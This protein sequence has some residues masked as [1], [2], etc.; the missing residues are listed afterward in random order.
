[1][2]TFPIIVYPAIITFWYSYVSIFKRLKA[3]NQRFNTNELCHSS[4]NVYVKSVQNEDNSN[5][6]TYSNQ[7]NINIEDQS[8]VTKNSRSLME[9]HVFQLGIRSVIAFIACWAPIS[10]YAVLKMTGIFN[11][12]ESM[13]DLEYCMFALAFLNSIINPLLYFAS[14]KMRVRRRHNPTV[15][16]VSGI[17]TMTL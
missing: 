5:I 7:S 2:I 3:Q 12:W 4:L 6:P 9:R 8:N 10:T 15:S 13:I 16:L 1:M 14:M 11:S 17:R